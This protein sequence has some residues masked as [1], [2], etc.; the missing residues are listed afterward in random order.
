MNKIEH[1]V[2]GAYV[3]CVTLVS[4]GAGFASCRLTYQLAAEGVGMGS[5]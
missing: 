4:S 3:L 1:K 2:E 5:E